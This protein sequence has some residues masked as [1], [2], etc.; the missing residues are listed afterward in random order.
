MPARAVTISANFVDE[1]VTFTLTVN[2]NPPGAGKVTLNPN[3]EKYEPEDTVTVTFTPAA[4][5]YTFEKWTG[6]STSTTLSVK[7]PMNGDKTLT[8]E[9]IVPT[10]TDTRPG[11]KTYRTVVIGGKT[12]MAENLNYNVNN[13]SWCY[14]DKSENCDKYGRL[15][16]YN[17]VKATTIC[18]AGWHLAD[19]SEWQGLIRATG[20]SVSVA[21]RKLKS[22]A[23]WNS[24][25]GGTDDFGFT[26]L[27][28]GIRAQ[29]GIYLS[30][31]NRGNWWTSDVKEY[32]GDLTIKP[33]MFYMLG[34]T[35]LGVDSQVRQD[36]GNE[37]ETI[38]L[39]VRCVQ[40]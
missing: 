2:V 27:P 40:D 9:V 13:G 33:V 4:G 6:A 31:G 18:P 34:L 26:A 32:L 1:A 29:G 39:S 7:I 19:T 22:T 28:G 20:D 5:G 16:N 3:K 35:N 11:G 36:Y 21:G 30:A 37:D 23:G 8:A 24:N 17:T 25:S 15:Y 10:F 12:W 14:D 38:G